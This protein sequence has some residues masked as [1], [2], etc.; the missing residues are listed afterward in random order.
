[1]YQQGN[2]QHHD[3]TELTTPTRYGLPASPSACE[4]SI[5]NASAVDRRTGITTYCNRNSQ[6]LA[7]IVFSTITGLHK[8]VLRPTHNQ[9]STALQYTL[10]QYQVQ[11]HL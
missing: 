3:G 4:I 7:V 2:K 6:L 5:W 8:T 9:L 1:M 11:S 10:P